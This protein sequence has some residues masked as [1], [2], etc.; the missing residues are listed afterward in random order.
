MWLSN[1]REQLEDSKL[2]GNNKLKSMSHPETM[3]NVLRHC[4]KLL[5]QQQSKEVPLKEVL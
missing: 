2:C 3:L 4:L 5:R 1:T